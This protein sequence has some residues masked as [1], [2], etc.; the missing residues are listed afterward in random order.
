MSYDEKKEILIKV[1]E[2]ADLFSLVNNFVIIE[3]PFNTR[4]RSNQKS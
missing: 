3:L 1:K 4:K 2:N